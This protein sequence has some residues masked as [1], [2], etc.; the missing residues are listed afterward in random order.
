MTGDGATLGS[1]GS[2]SSRF[3][4]ASSAS[5]GGDEGPILSGF[6]DAGT[7][8]AAIGPCSAASQLVYVLSSDGEIYSF[9]PPT[10]VFTDIATI[11]CPSGN[12]VPNSMAVDRQGNAWVNYVYN[13]AQGENVA[14][15]VFKVAIATGSCEVT[16][17]V[18]PA[19]WVHIGMGFS[20]A[21]ATDS[22]DTL[23]VAG[24]DLTGTCSD[25]VGSSLGLGSIDTIAGTLSPI[26]PFSGG[27][28]RQG[29]ELTGTGDGRLF[30]FFD[31]SV[32]EVA[33]IDKVSG[34]TS[35]PISMTGV[36]CPWDFAFSF[37]GGDFYLYT[38][39]ENSNSSVTHYTSADGGI[40][41]NYVPD[42]G[43]SIVGAG[44][45]TCAPTAQPR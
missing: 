1:E 24:D 45:S 40:D 13:D 6:S 34:A 31:L 36:P 28:L 30:G 4:S 18:L 29:A 41:P 11:Q 12:A 25:A 14:G 39:R 16:N 17:I 32:A 23:Y 43:F 5:H 10:K 9:D 20:S 2:S 27:L 21:S 37:W 35:P 22:T 38:S 7:A 44:V 33:Q 15:A 26:G 19:G 3:S 8:S 42:T